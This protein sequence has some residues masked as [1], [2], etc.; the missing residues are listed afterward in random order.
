VMGHS[1]TTTTMNRYARA[2]Q[3]AT[4]KGISAIDKAYSL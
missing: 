4:R 3:A 1:K 2:W